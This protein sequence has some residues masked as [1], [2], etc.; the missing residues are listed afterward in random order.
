MAVVV[1]R[2]LQQKL[3]QHNIRVSILDGMSFN[4]MMGATFP[5]MGLYILRLGGSEQMVGWLTSVPPIVSL[6]AVLAAAPLVERQAQKLPLIIKLN[7]ISRSFFLI[8]AFIPLL[9]EKLRPLALIV[10]WSVMFIPWAAASVAWTPMIST[11]I[12]EHLRGKF[13]GNRNTLAGMVALMSTFVVGRVLDKV[14]FLTAFSAVFIVSFVAVMLSQYFVVKQREPVEEIPGDPPPIIP[15]A[16][17]VKRVFTHPERGRR[18]ALFCGGIL[19]FHFGLTSS[20]PLYPVRQVEELGFSNGLIG[21]LSTIAS[22]AGLLGNYTG[23]RIIHRWGY[24][25]L[26]LLTTMGC[27]LSPLVWAVASSP[28][29]LG[30][31]TLVG[32]FFAAGYFLCQFT[33]VLELAPE[34]G[35]SD[36]V[37]LNSATANLAGAVGPLV[38]TFVVGAVGRGT[39]IGLMLSSTIMVLGVGILWYMVRHQ[40]L[41]ES[42]AAAAPVLQA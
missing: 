33:M 7:Y 42:K 13:F 23:G 2:V 30:I 41:T 36:Y 34:E 22:A 9:P 24:S 37:A 26:L 21:T 10:C 3:L 5:Y 27:I 29:V 18:F 39:S 28:W 19:V 16:Q 35:L 31:A 12:P 15:F 38:G 8:I 14:P 4:I 1:N 20:W 17:R 40:S 11:M 6:L 25:R 32:N